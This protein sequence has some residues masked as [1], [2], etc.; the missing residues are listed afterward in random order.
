MHEHEMRHVGETIRQ[1]I[2]RTASSVLSRSPYAV[3]I[4]IG[5]CLLKTVV[6]Q[7]GKNEVSLKAFSMQATGG[8]SFQEEASQVY[9]VESIRENMTIPLQ[10]IGMALSGPSVFVKPLSLPEM[11]EEDLR[12]HLSLE[13][14][15]YIV[16]DAQDALWDVYHPKRS[17]GAASS[18][19]E[20][21]LAVAKKVCVESWITACRQCGVTVRFVDVDAFALINMVTYNYGHK[22]ACLLA[23][24]GPTGILMIVIREGEP[25]YIRKVSF[26][27]EWYGDFLDQV[28]RGQA[29]LESRKELGVSEALL[30]EQFFQEARNQIVETVESFFDLSGQDLD[31][32][33]LLSG[34][35]VVAPEMS[36]T[37]AAALRMPVTLV[38]P[39]QEIAVPEAMQQDP[40]FQQIA[41]LLSVAVGVA[42][43]GART[44]D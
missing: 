32:G 16:L 13:L 35:Y 41:P 30:L 4:D 19:Q 3:G 9:L 20:Y 12:E 23:H 28:L 22:G 1:R 18:E 43:R 37:L 42:L 33:I 39:F 31:R 24:M 15:R 34:G 29:A 17:H 21:F 10:S 8:T 7:P 6:L 5:S 2:G 40:H 38:D 36:S 27:V 44:H 11:T 26:Q 14:D 25:A